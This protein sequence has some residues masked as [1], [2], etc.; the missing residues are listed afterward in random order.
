LQNAL[1]VEDMVEKAPD[2][3]DGENA[4]HVT[5]QDSLQRVKQSRIFNYTKSPLNTVW[6]LFL[7]HKEYVTFIRLAT[8]K[9][10]VIATEILIIYTA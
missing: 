10:S 3:M 9:I 4:E 5:V 2:G 8:R 7:C 6:G 1:I